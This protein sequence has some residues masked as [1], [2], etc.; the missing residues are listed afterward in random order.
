MHPC[1]AGRLN[2]TNHVVPGVDRSTASSNVKTLFTS[3]TY[4]LTSVAKTHLKHT[5]LKNVIYDIGT[6]I[7]YKTCFGH[8]ST[9][10]ERK[11]DD[12]L[13]ESSQIFLYIVN[14]RSKQDLKHFSKIV[15]HGFATIGFEKVDT[16]DKHKHWIQYKLVKNALLMIVKCCLINFKSCS[17]ILKC[18]SMI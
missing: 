12:F 11:V 2:E 4:S 1:F 9:Q 14:L 13:A 3:K 15:I 18:S 16:S 8:K 5:L 17:M 6:E 10:N 7:L